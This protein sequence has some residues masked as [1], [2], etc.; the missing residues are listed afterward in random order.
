[1]AEPDAS[2]QH[3]RILIV[4]LT[5][6]GD[7]IHGLPVLCALRDQLPHARLGWVVEGRA[8]ALLRGHPALDDLITVRRRWLKSP[9][10][11]RQLRQQLRQ[12]HFDVA[13]DVQGLTKSAMAAW[14][15]GAPQ[16]IGF[17]DEKGRELSRWLNTHLVKTRADHV[18]DCNLELLEPLGITSPKVRFDVPEQPEDRDM[19]EKL[20][21]QVGVQEGFALITPGAG[22]PSKVWPADRFAAVANYLGRAWGLPTIV[23]WAGDQER[24]WG[25][26]IVAAARGHAQLAPATSLTEL[27]ALARRARLFVGSDTG[28]LHLAA[29][30]GTPCVG[31]YGPMPAARNGP[32]G[33]QHVAL[34][35]TRFEGTSRQRRNAPREVIESILVDHVCDACDRILRRNTCHAA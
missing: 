12:L 6:I 26:E 13:I 9:S 25:A 15:S 34:E 22:W 4:R 8:G 5:A 3:L 14:L 21:A 19:A 33:P 2:H 27:A 30:V 32:Y 31:L 7:V 35:K 11:V 20:I 10:A 16:R 17:G 28:P 29:A 23:V 18:I 1:M 24:T